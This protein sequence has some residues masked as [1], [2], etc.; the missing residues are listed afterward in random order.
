M[1]KKLFSFLLWLPLIVCL[2]T[3]YS[4]SG[5]PEDTITI[6]NYSEFLTDD[7][8]KNF[9]VFFDSTESTLIH[10]SG[11]GISGFYTILIKNDTGIV[12]FEKYGTSKIKSPCLMKFEKTENHHLLKEISGSEK[13]IKDDY[14]FLIF[15]PIL[16]KD[17]LVNKYD[18]LIGLLVFIPMS[19]YLFGFKL[20]GFAVWSKKNY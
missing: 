16:T 7:L 10:K 6:K 18:N 4:I 14:G 5:Q 9:I 2:G 20:Y 1:K 13:F 15:E 8:R 12:F 3:A 11:R 19:V 17:E